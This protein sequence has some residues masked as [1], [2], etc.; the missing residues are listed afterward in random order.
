MPSLS[1]QQTAQS[2]LSWWSD[3]NL[4]GATINLHAASKPLMGLLYHQQVLGFIKKNHSTIPLSQGALEI[5][6]SYLGYDALSAVQIPV[7]I[8]KEDHPFELVNRVESEDEAR[9]VVASLVFDQV[10]DL[11]EGRSAEVREWTSELLGRL[12]FH[13]S[14]ATAVLRFCSQLGSLLQ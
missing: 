8:D 12:A 1:R 3:R 11:L 5:S 4:P 7:A 14:T 2:T 9:A 6:S 13:E 10:P